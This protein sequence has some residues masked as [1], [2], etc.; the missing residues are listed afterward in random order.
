MTTLRRLLFLSA[1]RLGISL[2]YPIFHVFAR[3]RLGDPRADLLGIVTLLGSRE[4]KSLPTHG[5]SRVRAQGL[6]RGHPAHARRVPGAAAYS[7]IPRVYP[8]VYRVVGIQGG[9]Y[10]Q[11]GREAYIQGGIYTREAWEACYSRYSR[12]IP[13]FGR[14]GR[15]VIPGYS[16]VWEA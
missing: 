12:V 3:E 2:R 13:G 14:P 16:R 11:G 9:I 6:F 4:P 8:E 15:P 5:Y 1:L 7:G 10:T